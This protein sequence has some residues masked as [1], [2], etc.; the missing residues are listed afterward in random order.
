MIRVFT[1][2]ESVLKKWGGTSLPGFLDIN[3]LKIYYQNHPQIRHLFILDTNV[4]LYAHIFNLNFNKTKHYLNGNSLKGFLL[5][6]INFRVL[7]LTNSFI[8]NVPSFTTNQLINLSELLD[9]IKDNYS[10][11]VIP[12]VLFEN[13]QT[14]DDYIK[15]EV[16]EE[17]F[18]DIRSE[19]NG[20]E[21][22]MLD[23]RKKYR[24]KLK[25]IIK[26][27][28]ALEVRSLDADSLEDYTADMQQLFNQIVNSSQFK[29][30]EFNTG[31]F[32][33]FVR[34]GFMIVHGYFLND[35][36]IGFSS[37]IEKD[38]VLYSYFVGFDKT[39][40]TSLPIY[41]RILIE[42]INNAI[43]LKKKRL[44]L[45]R[46]ANEFK[47]NFGAL[48]IRSFVYLKFKNRFL[49]TILSSVYSNLSI[50]K[51]KQRNPFRRNLIK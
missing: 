1:S 21:D 5:N 10:L 47:S 11:I 24:A 33:S 36:L 15:I 26:K 48:P 34:E 45:G 42:T 50:P 40:N 30:P 9:A 38:E 16:E 44:I 7:Y 32:S 39:L 37:D 23:L 51:W 20:L 3:F 13:V 22:Y 41:A 6:I 29:G 25:N 27:T 19:W 18:L 12:E 43:R 46:T 49:S 4:R 17:M 28:S 35:K 31:S 14:D 8:T 2:I